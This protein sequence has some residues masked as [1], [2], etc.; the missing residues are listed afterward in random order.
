M[1]ATPPATLFAKNVNSM[2]KNRGT[3]L[4][5]MCRELGWSPSRITLI[6][7]G[8]LPKFDDML[9]ICKYLDCSLLELWMDIDDIV[10]T[11][12]DE[13][14]IITV[15]R[16]L[17]RRTKHEFMTQLYKLETINND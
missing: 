11:D 1:R 15:F 5:A 7:N 2:C 12:E 4:S 10:I 3:N 13:K 16:S 8:T 14:E 9:K 6:N 17:D